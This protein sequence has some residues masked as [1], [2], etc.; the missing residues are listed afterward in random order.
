LPN[1]CFARNK[2]LTT[3]EVPKTLTSIGDKAFLNCTALSSLST[4]EGVTDVGCRAFDG[5]SITELSLPSVTTFAQGALYGMTEL[6][7]L[8]IPFIGESVDKPQTANFLF[9]TEYDIKRPKSLGTVKI[10]NCSSLEN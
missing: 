2:N 7:N 10:T 4:L 5:T 9:K 6:I 8:T 1:S 3:V